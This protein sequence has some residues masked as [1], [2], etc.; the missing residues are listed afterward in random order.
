M[1][2]QHLQPCERPKAINVLKAYV[3][4][5]KPSVQAAHAANTLGN[6]SI[7]DDDVMARA[8]ASADLHHPTSSLH[9]HAHSPPPDLLEPASCHLFGID[10]LSDLLPP[11]HSE[12]PSRAQSATPHASDMSSLLAFRTDSNSNSRAAPAAFGGGS[13][14]GRPWSP[15]GRL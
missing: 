3:H 4:L 13:G 12:P 10:G 7:N 15:P 2:C 6:S 11:A 14:G 1:A 8:T 9:Q 5:L